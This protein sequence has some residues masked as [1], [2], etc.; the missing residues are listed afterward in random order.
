MQYLVLKLLWQ[1][2]EQ[3]FSL[4]GLTLTLTMIRIKHVKRGVTKLLCLYCLGKSTFDVK[5]RTF[6]CSFFVIILQASV[7]KKCNFFPGGYHLAKE[8]YCIIM[9]TFW[10]FPEFKEKYFG[11]VT[12]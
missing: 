8:N 11:T 1:V 5:R 10:T 4:I 12:K 6:S 3:L 9:R 2:I 7:V